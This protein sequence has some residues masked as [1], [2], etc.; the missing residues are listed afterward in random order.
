MPFFDFVSWISMAIFL[1]GLVFVFE[2]TLSSGFGFLLLI[3]S[4]IYFATY[5]W[6]QGMIVFGIMFAV[7]LILAIRFLFGEIYA[8][9]SRFK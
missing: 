2:A 9:R 6:E 4:C 7:F 5:F 3:G 1:I 8:R